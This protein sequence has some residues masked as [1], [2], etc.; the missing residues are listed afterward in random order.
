MRSF[1]PIINYHSPED[2]GGWTLTVA[3][4]IIKERQNI[5]LRIKLSKNLIKSLMQKLAKLKYF[6][7]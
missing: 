7:Y 6:Y 5:N 4:V 2:R 1:R 3:I